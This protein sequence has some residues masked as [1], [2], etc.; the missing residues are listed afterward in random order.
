MSISTSLTTFDMKEKRLQL[1][2]VVILIVILPLLLYVLQK[3]LQ[4][5]IRGAPS[6]TLS[7]IPRGMTQTPTVPWDVPL[8]SPSTMDVFLETGSNAIEAVEVVV[9]YDPVVVSFLPAAG[10]TIDSIITCSQVAALKHRW[11]YYVAGV[12]FNAQGVGTGTETGT[13]KFICSSVPPVTQWPAPPGTKPTYQPAAANFRG[14]VASLNFRTKIVRANNQFQLQFTPQDPRNDSTA[15]IYEGQCCSVTEGLLNVTNLSFNVGGGG[16]NNVNVHIMIML[17][18]RTGTGASNAR[19]VAVK[20]KGTAYE[21]SPVT[22]HTDAVGTGETGPLAN[23][24]AGSYRILLKP[25]GYLQRGFNQSLQAGLNHVDAT[26]P[27]FFAGDLD[28]SGKVNSLDYA[29]LLQKFGTADPLAD[30]DGSGLVNSLDHS[31][32]LSNWNKTGDDEGV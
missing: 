17:Q 14:A 11:A 21:Q 8:N 19:Y 7:L 30:F 32:L 23:L 20:V 25:V 10:Q 2:I 27:P 28:G 9:T 26:T 1:I 29:V 22:V 12:T 15:L 6:A 13:V 3:A 24:T 16:P 5:R 4:L 31:M 18:G